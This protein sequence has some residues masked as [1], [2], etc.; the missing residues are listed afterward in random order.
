MLYALATDIAMI[1]MPGVGLSLLGDRGWLEQSCTGHAAWTVVGHNDTLSPE[2][3]P[4]DPPQWVDLIG[5]KNRTEPL[6]G[7]HVACVRMK[8]VWY[9]AGLTMLVFHT[10]DGQVHVP[11]LTGYRCLGIPLLLLRIAEILSLEDSRRRQRLLWTDPNKKPNLFRRTMYVLLVLY[12][13]ACS[14]KRRSHRGMPRKATSLARFFRALV[15]FQ[16]Q[17]IFRHRKPRLD[18]QQDPNSLMVPPA[19]RRPVSEASFGSLSSLLNLYILPLSPYPY[20]RLEQIL[21]IYPILIAL[22]PHLHSTDFR[23]LQ[24]TSR[25]VRAAIQRSVGPDTSAIAKLTCGHIGLCATL[26]VRAQ[27]VLCND[28]LC[29]LSDLVRI[30]RFDS[31]TVKRLLDQCCAMHIISLDAHIDCVR[32]C[33]FCLLK[34]KISNWDQNQ[35]DIMQSPC[36]CPGTG[37]V[38][39][40]GD[41]VACSKRRG[42]WY[43]KSERCADCNGRF[44]TWFSWCSWQW[45]I[46]RGTPGHGVCRRDCFNPVYHP[47]R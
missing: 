46:H 32:I 14:K 30:T 43:G 4:R 12:P 5:S 44:W 28:N 9:M 21:S 8:L 19:S 38:W 29:R 39:V 13:E 17:P 37:N 23:A 34:W 1:V 40:C 26:F 42:G 27:C 33:T 25:T 35:A 31:P 41:R 15:K 2:W 7:P 18:K 10:I 36:R 11:S 3:R 16:W 47:T 24:Q 22:I 20:R 45:W 6:S